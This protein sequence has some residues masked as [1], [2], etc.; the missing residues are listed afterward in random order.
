MTFAVEGSQGTGTAT[1]PLAEIEIDERKQ[2]PFSLRFFQ[3]IEVPIELPLDFQP[4]RLHVEYQLG[5]NREPSQAR[6][7]TGA[8]KAGTRRH[9]DP[10]RARDL[11]FDRRMD[12]AWTKP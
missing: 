8:W 10:R 11:Q 2:F 12:P 5:R 3:Q 1:L 9:F 4:E 7:S 6:R